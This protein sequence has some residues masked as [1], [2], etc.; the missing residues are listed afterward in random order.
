MPVDVGTVGG[1]AALGVVLVEVEVE[2]A[3]VVDGDRLGLARARGGDLFFVGPGGAEDLDPV[4]VADVDPVAGAGGDELGAD[5]ERRPLGELPVGGAERAD[6]A[7]IA[8]GR[9]AEVFAAV[10]VDFAAEHQH[11]VAFGVEFLHPVVFQVD[12]VDVAGRVDRQPFYPAE[13]PR[14]RAFAARLTAAFRGAGLRFFGRRAGVHVPAERLHEHPP[15]GELVHPGVVV[16]GEVDVA[17]G[18]ID[19]HSQ[20]VADL[21]GPRAA[22]RPRFGHL[23]QARRRRYGARGHASTASAVR[24]AARGAAKRRARRVRRPALLGA[25]VSSLILVYLASSGCRSGGAEA[26]ATAVWIGGVAAAFDAWLYSF[27]SAT[28][29]P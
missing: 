15:G 5:E 6:P 24:E 4:F 18:L 21:P 20:G 17:A 29:L 13:L 9:G 11:E 22:R 7:F 12:H 10:L 14:A 16:V 23:P 2:V 3:R 8:G 27:T 28:Q 25:G 1:V 26:A 19:R